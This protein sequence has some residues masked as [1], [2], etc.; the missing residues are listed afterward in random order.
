MQLK[1]FT[2]IEV[3]VTVAIVGILAAIAY[4][5]YQNHV[6]KTRRK[7]AEACLMEL[8]QFMERYYTTNMSYAGASLPSTQCE[9]DLSGYYTFAFDGTPSATSFALKAT[10]A[11]VQATKDASCTPLKVTHTGQKTPSECW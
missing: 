9:T 6:V 11:G 3:M 2:L 4:P 8:T 7:A 1:G 5:S 10:A